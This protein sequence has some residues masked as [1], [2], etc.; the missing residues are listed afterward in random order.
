VLNASFRQIRTPITDLRISITDR[1]N[2][3]CA[4]CRTG[5]EGALRRS[6]FADYA[7]GARVLTGLGVQKVRITGGEPLLRG[8]AV[9]FV[10]QLAKLRTTSGEE[11][12]IAL[13]TNGHLLKRW[14]S[15]SRTLACVRLRSVDAVDSDRFAR[16]T[17]VRMDMTMC[18]PASEPPPHRSVAGE[19]QLRV[20][21]GFNEDQIIPFGR[22]ARE[23][24]VVVRF[25][26]FMPLEEDRVWSRI[27]WFRSKRFCVAWPNTVPWSKSRMDAGDCAPLPLRRWRR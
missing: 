3:K 23:E 25:I 8:K 21:R 6:P 9:E 2:Y 20:M 4:H 5:N 15:P 1:C 7:H 27:P 26:E 24:G 14:H 17:R 13:T 12:D 16:I 11:L 10:R 19:S 22:F 18:L